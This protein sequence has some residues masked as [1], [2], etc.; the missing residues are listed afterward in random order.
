MS[1]L[2]KLAGDAVLYGIPTIFGRLLNWLMVAVHTRAFEDP[3]MLLE[4]S[5]LYV[6]IIPL[7][8]LYAFGLE[9]AFF[10]FA[11]KKENQ[12]EYFNIILSFILVF[13]S[14]LSGLIILFSTPISVALNLPGTENLISLLAVI[15]LV[16]AATSIAFV[17]LRAQ[18]KAKKFATIKMANILINIASTLF[19][20]YFAHNIVKGVFLPE[21]KPWASSFYS[22]ANGPD[23]LIFSNYIASLLT[24]L[25]LWKEFVGFK[26][27]WNTEKLKVLLRYSWP[28]MLMGLAGTINLTADRLLLR[29]FLPVGFYP[30]FPDVETAFSIYANVY[31][32]S[33]F[34]TLAVQAYRYAA[35]PIFFSKLGE[36]NSPGMIALSTKWFTILCIVI[37]LSVSININWLGNILGQN[38]RQGFFILPILLLANLFIGLYNNLAIW[39]KLSD[40]TRF[41]T[42]ITLGSM[43]TTVA[44]NILLIPIW[45][46]MG[47]AIAFLTSSF[48]MVLV[49]YL[50]G[51]KHYPIPYETKKIVVYLAVAALIIWAHTYLDSTNLAKAI[52]IQILMC[53]AFVGFVFVLERKAWVK[54]T[55]E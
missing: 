46:F 30:D 43:V 1:F 20:I 15:L 10:R 21:L 17:K 44:L 33:I 12:S 19:F 6:Y 4:N 45:G 54:Q 25:M 29:S 37:W 22:P 24:L 26:L 42:Y 16:D 23:F 49:C 35:E 18:N 11:S 55:N 50:L 51:Q 53:I 27:V 47:C 5:Q 3:K 34:M 32:L 36:K 31:K 9:T 52:V 7:N 13:G 48:L 38:Y 39:F 8:I 40:Q 2:K 41:G 28:L 14:T